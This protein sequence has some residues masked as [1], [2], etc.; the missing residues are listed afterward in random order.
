MNTADTKNVNIAKIMTPKISTVFLH[1]NNTVLDALQIIQNH[2][3][4]AIPVLDSRDQYIGSITEGDLLRYILALGTTDMNELAKHKINGL[5]RMDFCPPLDISASL[6]Q[7]AASAMQQNFIP[8]V[9]S[10]GCLCGIV[11]RR[12]II[13]TL[14]KSY[15]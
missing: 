13:E 4:T 11:T 10:R 2:G 9:D 1:S 12:A 3:Y 14:Y 15:Q 5:F 7:I 6:D 8:I